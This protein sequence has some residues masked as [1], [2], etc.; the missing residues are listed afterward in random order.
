MEVSTR[1]MCVLNRHSR[2]QIAI[3]AFSLCLDRNQVVGKKN[4]RSRRSSE[5][6]DEKFF[7]RREV[8]FGGKKTESFEDK[9]RAPT[10]KDEISFSKR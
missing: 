7:Y 8:S 2:N 4:R 9:M 1:S 3:S 6:Q 5:A 10:A